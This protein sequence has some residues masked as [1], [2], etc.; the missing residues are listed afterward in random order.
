M[1]FF[2]IFFGDENKVIKKWQH[3]FASNTNRSAEAIDGVLQNFGGQKM[4][5]IYWMSENMD[6]SPLFPK[7]LKH[8]R[9][10]FSGPPAIQVQKKYSIDS[11][12]TLPLQRGF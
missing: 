12:T 5:M 3:S 2:K 7:E 9:K 10:P 4:T 8:S 6:A 11:T 1:L